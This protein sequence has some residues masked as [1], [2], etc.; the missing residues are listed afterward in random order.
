MPAFTGVGIGAV[1]K[2]VK[3]GAN[4]VPNV[5]NW[6]LNPKNETKAY[7]SSSTA[8]WRKR[9]K[10]VSDISGSFDLKCD[11][12]TKIESLISPGDIIA[13]ELWY[14]QT[15]YHAGSACIE[16]ISYEVD[17]DTGNIVAAT[18][19]FSGNGVWTDF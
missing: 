15:L 14:N 10:S 8:G 11:D 19:T 18:V 2:G 17:L 7:A 4:F 13:M 3:L 5:T 12:T 6:K 9:L 1:S 16:D